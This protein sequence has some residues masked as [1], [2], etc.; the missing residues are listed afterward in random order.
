MAKDEMNTGDPTGT[1][2][3]NPVGLAEETD[4]DGV[5]W[6]TLTHDIDGKPFL[7]DQ[8]PK[9]IKEL[10]EHG[11]RHY[12]F[13]TERMKILKRETEEK[14][15]LTRLYGKYPEQF[16]RSEN[17]PNLKIYAVGGLVID[18]VITETVNIKTEKDSPP[19]I[20]VEAQNADAKNGTDAA[21][22]G[23]K[24]KK[25]KTPADVY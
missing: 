19:P 16:K 7:P 11:V 22:T 25:G 1:G 6:V 8:Q 5:V 13:K 9:A 18:A 12:N 15:E 17:D 23:A 2:T 4:A 21:K 14:V 24:G 20:S 10:W 3:P